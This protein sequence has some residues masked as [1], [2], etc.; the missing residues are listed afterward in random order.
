MES[1]PI[2]LLNGVWPYWFKDAIQKQLNKWFKI[3]FGA[4]FGTGLFG[5]VFL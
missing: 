4:L 3:Y 2:D 5:L 1:D